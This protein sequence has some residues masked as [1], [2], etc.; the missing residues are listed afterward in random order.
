[1]LLNESLIVT[2][3]MKVCNG[4]TKDTTTLHL[5]N[6]E[7]SKNLKTI[8][9]RNRIKFDEFLLT[10]PLNI[11]SYEKNINAQNH[12]L[13]ILTLSPTCFEVDFNEGF[14]TIAPIL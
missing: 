4:T 3:S 6:R 13:L 10:L 2:S 9:S 7:K 1:M 5:E 11:R 8:I 12:S 14:V